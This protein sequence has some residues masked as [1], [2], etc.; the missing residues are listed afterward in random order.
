MCD[1]RV[2]VPVSVSCVCC[3]RWICSLR[4]RGWRVEVDGRGSCLGRGGKTDEETNVLRTD[5]KMPR[6]SSR[7]KRTLG[8]Y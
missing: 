2:C 7:F 6:V 3:V 1:V 5:Q 4:W 8:E